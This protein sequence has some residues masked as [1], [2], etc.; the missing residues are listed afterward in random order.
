MKILATL[1]LLALTVTA[2]AAPGV[3]RKASP[4]PPKQTIDRFEQ[5]VKQKGMTIFA[6]IDHKANANKAG[7]DMNDAELLIFGNPTVGT[8]IMNH[9]PAAGL[10]L[11]LRVLAYTDNDGNNWL[12]YHDPATLKRHFHVDGCMAIEKVSDAMDKLTNAAVATKK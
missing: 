2:V 9:D 8:R 7:M 5:I 3:I 10:D 11:P 6:R 4:Y 1:L 12:I